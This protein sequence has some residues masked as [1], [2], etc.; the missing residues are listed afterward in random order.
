MKRSHRIFQFISETGILM[1][2]PRSHKQHL[3]NAFDTVASH[4][5]HTS[6]ISYCLARMEGLSHEKGIHAMT[7]SVFHDIPEARTGDLNYVEKHY[8]TANEEKALNDQLHDLPF[9][10]DLQELFKEYTSRETLASKCAKDADIINQL[11][12]EWVLD[13]MG[14]KMAKRWFTL[15]YKTT[16]PYLRTKSAKKIALEIPKT[17]PHEWW[18]S[19]LIEKNLNKK[20]LNG[21]K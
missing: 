17:H 6:I 21:E 11:Y 8:I 4:S 15:K 14:N 2:M 20:H 9:E 16:V 5:H 18:F 10:K 12:Q 13:F 1:Q 7:M 3:G 19:Q